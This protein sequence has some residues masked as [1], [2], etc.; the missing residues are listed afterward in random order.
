[1]QYVITKLR[2]ILINNFQNILCLRFLKITEI[3]SVFK[4]CWVKCAY[5]LFKR[6][7]QCAS[8]CDCGHVIY[9]WLYYSLR[10]YV[11]D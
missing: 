9:G 10:D 1:M 3:L 7:S 11:Y 8:V 5:V 6:M 4:V 2:T